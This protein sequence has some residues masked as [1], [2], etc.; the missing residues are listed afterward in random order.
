[1][2]R[3]QTTHDFS[4]LSWSLNDLPGLLHLRHNSVTGGMLEN[5]KEGK[6][7]QEIQDRMNQNVEIMIDE[8]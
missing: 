2:H 1:M 8:D 7:I 6:G 4:Q 5:P 3:R